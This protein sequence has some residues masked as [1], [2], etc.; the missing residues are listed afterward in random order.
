LG[1]ITAIIGIII[2]FSKNGIR[3]NIKTRQYVNYTKLFW[4][5]FGKEKSFQKY[6]DISILKKTLVSLA[7]SRALIETETSRKIVFDVSILDSSHR[8]K[9]VVRRETN[10]EAAKIQAKYLSE[11]LGMNYVNYNPVRTEKTMERR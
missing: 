5:I 6:C 10:F 1:P 7:Y 8:K 9:I 4:M 11:L 3:L 2:S